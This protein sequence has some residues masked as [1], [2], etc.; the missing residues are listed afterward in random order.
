M[1][2]SGTVVGRGLASATGSTCAPLPYTIVRPANTTANLALIRSTIARW[3]ADVTTYEGLMFRGLV[4]NDVPARAEF[5]V[6]V[7][8]DVEQGLT[9]GVCC[10]LIAATIDNFVLGV[11]SYTPIP[12]NE[13]TI[14]LL[15]VDPRNVPGAPLSPKY[16]GVGTAMVAALATLLVQNGYTTIFLHPLDSA[17]EAFWRGRGFDTCGRGG[18]LCVR[19]KDRISSLVDGCLTREDNPGDGHI[20]LCGLPKRV[21]DKLLAH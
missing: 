3:Q 16:R 10:H 12:P 9:L 1:A 17:A 4:T 6:D 11:M 2:I 8:K 15:A 18:L 13:A 20:V 7:L 5:A 21:R 14:N 19:G